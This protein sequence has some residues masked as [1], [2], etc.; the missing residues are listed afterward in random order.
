MKT[1][2][3]IEM[4]SYSSK[5]AFHVVFV[6]LVLS[7]IWIFS[8]DTIVNNYF[9]DKDT[10]ELISLIKGWLFVTCTSILIYI[11]VHNAI[12]AIHSQKEKIE[13]HE[14]QL[15]YIFD[16]AS[17]GILLM[18]N[19]LGLIEVNQKGLQLLGYNRDE[20]LKLN[21]SEIMADETNNQ[22]WRDIE[23]KNNSS[24]LSERNIIRKDGTVFQAEISARMMP[25]GDIQAIIR[26][27]TQRK[28][29]ED[30]LKKSGERYRSLSAHLQT[31]R[32][33]ERQSIA[34]E[35]H[36]ELGQILTS[37]KIN[38]SLIRRS[39]E[40]GENQTEKDGLFNEIVSMNKMIDH[41]VTSI[42]KI[43][44]QLRPELLDKLGLIAALEWY[45]QNFSLSSEIECS[46]S[47]DIDKLEL[48]ND[49]E[50]TIFRIVQEALTNVIK[51]SGAD[52]VNI[53]LNNNYGF[54]SLAIYDNGKGIKET[55]ITLDNKFGLLGMR[56][57]ASLINSEFEIIG[58]PGIG[59]T[60]ILKVKK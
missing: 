29:Y 17:D 13:F 1:G 31:I 53:T 20:M 55:D 41:A 47:S 19:Q 8:S 3:S 30:E 11:L 28:K 25:N 57:R 43:I 32:E 49:K 21:L 56:E 27:I 23:L 22:L 5:K 34:R 4:N 6:Y 2:F 12:K 35:M 15:Q 54:I 24:T 45:T 9:A 37:L 10:I 18:N 52:K 14:A 59:T 44:T 7:I 36:D 39:I 58:K 42:R 48:G 46:F 60:I 26:D 16:W 38:L 51:H 50:L 40:K 33:E